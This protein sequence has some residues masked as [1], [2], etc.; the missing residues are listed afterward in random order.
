M[1]V[2]MLVWMLRVRRLRSVLLGFLDDILCVWTLVWML[3]WMLRVR[4]LR[5]VL[6]GFLDDI[7]CV[8]ML[9][10]PCRWVLSGLLWDWFLRGPAARSGAEGTR[11]RGFLLLLQLADLVRDGNDGRFG[12][13]GLRS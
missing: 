8:W 13:L 7:L 1:L 5:S 6:L 10:R 3:V 4:R 11:T 12:L 9:V 2:W